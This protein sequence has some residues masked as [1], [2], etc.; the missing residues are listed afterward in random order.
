ME[1][2]Q[3]VTAGRERQDEEIMA[4]AIGMRRCL[5]NTSPGHMTPPFCQHW[6]ALPGR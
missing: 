3:D 6:F 2:G 1:D 5:D 4:E